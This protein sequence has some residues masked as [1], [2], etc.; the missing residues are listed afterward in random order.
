MKVRILTPTILADGV[1]LPAGSIGD[2]LGPP[3]EGYDGVP[4]LR[5]RFAMPD[6]V[7]GLVRQSVELTVPVDDLEPVGGAK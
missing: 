4:D 6:L 2:V 1:E 5:V 7:R 3:L